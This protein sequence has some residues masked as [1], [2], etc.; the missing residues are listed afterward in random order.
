MDILTLAIAKN[1]SSSADETITTENITNAL[2]YKPASQEDVGKLS[3]QKIDIPS[4]AQVGQTI[5]VKS[6]D[7][8][9]KPTEWKAVDMT[10]G[11]SSW[12]DLEDKPFSEEEK[13]GYIFEFDSDEGN[14]PPSNHNGT[15]T[16]VEDS[17]YKFVNG[18]TYTITTV[19]EYGVEI[20]VDVVCNN[21]ELVTYLVNSQGETMYKC[22][23]YQWEDESNTTIFGEYD[24]WINVGGRSMLKLYGH[25]GY[26]VKPLDEKYIPDT[27]AKK[28]DIQGGNN[29]AITLIDNGD[30]TYSVDKTY[31]EIIQAHCLEKR[32]LVLDTEQVP[33]LM[34][35]PFIGFLGGGFQFGI[36][37]DD[38]AT[39]PY[40]NPIPVFSGLVITPSDVVVYNKFLF[41]CNIG[42]LK[43]TNKSLI[44]AINELKAEIDALKGSQ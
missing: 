8:N 31:E 32:N 11:A 26:E 44:G 10:S 21:F 20:S 4:T 18:K 43:T 14:T 37:S 13:M 40:E 33:V 41:E 22:K 35:L 24:N 38:N 36:F 39:N 23:L 7:E 42:L 9:G 16:M 34:S 30:G 5:V 28:S 25:I 6:I 19:D 29:F 27:I 12:N 1:K 17:G 3:G 15:C 2:G